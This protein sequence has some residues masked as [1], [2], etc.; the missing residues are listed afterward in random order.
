MKN[1]IFILIFAPLSIFSQVGVNTTTPEET[2]HVEGTFRVTNTSTETP[3]KLTGLNS[4]GTLTDVTIGSNLSLTGSTLSANAVS[5]SS[6]T[7]YLV[8]TIPLADG[9]PGDKFN[10]LDMGV[11]TTNVDKVVFRFTGRT[12]NYKITG[13]SDGTDGRHL[14]LFNVSTSNMSV[15]DESTDS[16]PQNRIITLASNVATSGQGTAELV[17]DA[18]LQRWI[19][20]GFRD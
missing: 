9:S 17:Y 12:A 15:N 2:L 13:I 3:T 8:A 6:P 4:D 18:P 5:S 10:D 16:L 1:L 11:S 14:V 20:I 7:I 19:L